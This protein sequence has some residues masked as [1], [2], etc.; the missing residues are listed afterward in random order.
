MSC[1]LPAALPAADFH[2]PF[3]SSH[4]LEQ[5][6]VWGPARASE[7]IGRLN[8]FVAADEFFCP[9]VVR[10]TRFFSADLV[11]VRVRL[12]VSRS[13]F[14][15]LQNGS[16]A[17]SGGFE[18]DRCDGPRP[19]GCPV[20]HLQVSSKRIGFVSVGDS[21]ECFRW[22]SPSTFEVRFS[23]R[24]GRLSRQRPPSQP[25]RLRNFHPPVFGKNRER[26]FPGS[27]RRLVRGA[28]VKVAQ[29]PNEVRAT[30]T[31]PAERTGTLPAYRGKADQPKPHETF[32][33]LVGNRHL[34]LRF[35]SGCPIDLKTAGGSGCNPDD[36]APGFGCR[37]F[38][39]DETRCIFF[40]RRKTTRNIFC[41]G[42][43][44]PKHFNHELRHP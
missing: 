11:A 16:L 9:P 37:A 3:R 29:A 33:T 7:R 38:G 26:F 28:R 23:L 8:G 6:S 24:Q 32:G 43:R 1:F 14:R 30:L 19:V 13:G 20:E 35:V 27:G 44:Q 41:F 4:T 12:G 5:G 18:T 10:L 25:S 31:R 2:S 21:A 42:R 40:V 15:R 34:F 36:N 22:W 39:G 17:A